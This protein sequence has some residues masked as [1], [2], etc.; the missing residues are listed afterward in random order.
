[1][2][3]TP[4][5]FLCSAIDSSLTRVVYSL[6]FHLNVALFALRLRLNAAPKDS[7]LTGPDAGF[8]KL[9]P[10]PFSISVLETLA[11]GLGLT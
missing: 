4:N 3:F 2:P 1:M 8:F 5:F 10:L 7:S 6:S 11:L 9:I